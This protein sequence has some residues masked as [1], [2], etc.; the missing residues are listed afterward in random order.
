MAKIGDILIKYKEEYPTYESESTNRLN[1]LKRSF[2]NEKK[3]FK[4]IKE[5]NNQ[6]LE[7]NQANIFK[8]FASHHQDYLDKVQA[9]N[10]QYEEIANDFN[11]DVYNALKSLD[12]KA[13]KE[14]D[15]FEEILEAFESKRQDAFDIYLNLTKNNNQEIDQDMR[16]HHEFIEKE[17]KKLDKFKSYYDDL[18]AKLN[19]KLLWTIEKSKNAINQLENDLSTIERDDLFS[20]NKKIIQS[21]SDMRGTRNDINAMFKESSSLLQDYRESIYKIRK[22]KQR[23]YADVNQKLIQK[24]VKQIRIANDNKIK[25][26]TIIKN[27]LEESK[28]V[29]YPLIIKAQ[30]N[31]DTDKLE[32]YILQT[33]A[34]EQ[35]ANFLLE[36]INKITNYN[37]SS[38]QKRIK[39]IKIEAFTRNEEI[40][41]TYS[42]PVKFIENSVNI[43]SNYNFYFNQ[44]FNDLDKLLS[45]LIEFSQT[46]NDI[47]DKEILTN[48]KDFSDYQNTLIAKIKE[49]SEKLSDL[50]FNID[51]IAFNITTLESKHRLKIAEIKKEI[52]NVDIK[53]DYLKYIESL[54]TDYEIANNHYK[55]RLKKINIHKLYKDKILEIYKTSADL[56]KEIHLL[57]IDQEYNHDLIQIEASAHREIYDNLLGQLDSFYDYQ[58]K[59]SDIFMNMIKE[60]VTQ[61]VK[62]SNYHLVYNYYQLLNRH[63]ESIVKEENALVAFIKRMQKYIKDNHRNVKI[64]SNFIE[65]KSSTFSLKQYF[66]ESEDKLL[67]QIN[68]LEDKK[69]ETLQNKINGAYLDKK[70]IIL[71]TKKQI[72]R[73]TD[74]YKYLLDNKNHIHSKNVLNKK[75]FTDALHQFTL[76][77]Y[78]VLNYL[79]QWSAKSEIEKLDNYYD[80]F[81]ANFTEKYVKTSDKISRLKKDKK[82]NHLLFKYL[83]FTLD[84][85]NHT[86]DFFENLV[87]QAFEQ[88]LNQ[89]ATQLALIK[90]NVENHKS[91]VH[92]EYNQLENKTDKLHGKI[93]TQQKLIKQYTE[94]L[95]KHLTK[96]VIDKNKK[97]LNKKAQGKSQYAYL[98]KE[99]IKIIKKNDKELLHLLKHIN[100]LISYHYDSLQKDY[101]NHKKS[102]Q[103]QLQKMLFDSNVE[104]Q[105][106]AY[107]MFEYKEKVM[108]TRNQLIRQLDILPGEKQTRL[109]SI[110]SD[111]QKV[112]NK[113]Y[114][115]LMMTYAK[116]EKDKFSKT[117]IL[118]QKIEL[119]EKQIIEDYSALY[120]KHKSLED[121]YLNQYIHFNKSFTDFHKQFRDGQIVSTL[122]FDHDL[123]QPLVDLL[124][125]QTSMID[126]TKTIEKETALKTQLKL[127]EISQEKSD[128]EKKQNR[129]INS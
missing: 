63:N 121:H 120:E 75:Q 29:L 92:Y 25:Y 67:K 23:P 43:Y 54:N 58:K 91:Y 96:K 90:V 31:N 13:E 12:E 41:N 98:K 72:S 46:F 40:K 93:D 115:K 116:I 22:V 102:I 87:N 24:L 49:V 125:T 53:G 74:G 28:S 55:N 16:V 112:F 64:I 117:P 61:S 17:Q 84:A 48:K 105:Y 81:I 109:S 57:E 69:T 73:L 76:L 3:N 95:N 80:V 97:F 9:L 77:Y 51:E 108:T 60:K 30:D 110:E 66:K 6:K 65:D 106:N 114:D 103:N 123:N 36:K 79:Y 7:E 18:N 27:D 104:T 26:Q 78:D 32:K 82:I 94:D 124:N 101:K 10:H 127:N 4:N 15:L 113:Q 119:E 126:F 128:S 44:G 2:S 42:V 129:I 118:E 38:Y 59:L 21:L 45:Q 52:L 99:I 70:K 14:H 85:F 88:T 33:E 68:F 111:N 83:N 19:N 1:E 11:E 89:Y 5:S 56:N 71:K 35:K 50:L 20:L 39:E 122:S 47:R 107:M 100:K 34:L 86:L 37:T 8:Q 62:A